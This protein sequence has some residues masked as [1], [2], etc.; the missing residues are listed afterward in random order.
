MFFVSIPY[1]GKSLSMWDE[2]D[3]SRNIIHIK[4]KF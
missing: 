2:M 1:K 4:A 3:S